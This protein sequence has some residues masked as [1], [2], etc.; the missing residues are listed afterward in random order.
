MPRSRPASSGA[1]PPIAVDHHRG[2]GAAGGVRRHPS[3]RPCRRRASRPSIRRGCICRA[4]SSKA[5]S[6]ACWRPTAMSRCARSASN[7]PS[8]RPASWCR[9]IRR[10]RLRATSADVV[11]GILIQGTNV[12]TMLVPGYVSE[13]LMRFDQD[14]R[15]SDAL[16][17]VLL[18]R[19]RGHVGQGQGDRQGRLR[20]SREERREAELCWSIGSSS[21]LISGSPSRCSASRSRSAPGRCSSAARSAPGSPIPSSITAR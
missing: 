10:S 4:N 18:L 19:P 2:H 6:A 1:G 8:R 7:I 11:H 17:G 16:P 15:L 14:R 21:S 13:Q 9:R 3:A 20:Q 12:N 5:I